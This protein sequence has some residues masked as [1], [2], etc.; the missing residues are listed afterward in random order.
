MVTFVY[1][2]GEHQ[3][4]A[5]M[6]MGTSHCRIEVV[7]ILINNNHKF[8]TLMCSYKQDTEELHEY[9]EHFMSNSK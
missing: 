8:W 6:G 7:T 9:G 4:A 3:G 2:G 1:K 5:V